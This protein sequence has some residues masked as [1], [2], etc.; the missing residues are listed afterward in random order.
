MR[1]RPE[2]GL[3]SKTGK[4]FSRL[5][6][7]SPVRTWKREPDRL[8]QLSKLDKRFSRRPFYTSV[9]AETVLDTYFSRNYGTSMVH[10]IFLISYTNK[11]QLEPKSAISLIVAPMSSIYIDIA[12]TL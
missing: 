8:K 2:G 5:G 10:I 12:V 3:E 9:S 6:T 7:G 1:T 4:R 11:K